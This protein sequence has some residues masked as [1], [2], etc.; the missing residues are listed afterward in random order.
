MAA[1][2]YWGSSLIYNVAEA[3]VMME[4]NATLVMMLVSL[5]GTVVGYLIGRF[6]PYRKELFRDMEHRMIWLVCCLILFLL[7]WMGIMFRAR[8]GM[9]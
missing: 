8:L 2:G 4:G 9:E 3:E 1:I 5:M 6:D 7:I